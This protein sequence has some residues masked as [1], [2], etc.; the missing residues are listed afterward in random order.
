[1]LVW[2]QLTSKSLS[3]K[4]NAE[5]KLWIE[6]ETIY[7]QKFSLYDNHDKYKICYKTKPRVVNSVIS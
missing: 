1:M 5:R 4:W 2:Q 6:M 3:S 7:Q